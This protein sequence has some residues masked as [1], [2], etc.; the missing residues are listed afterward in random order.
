MMMPSKELIT[1]SDQDPLCRIDSFLSLKF[2]MHSRAYFQYL[3]ENQYIK[4]NGASIKKREK[5]LPGDQIEVTFHSKTPLN[6][7]PQE[8]PLSL[9]YEDDYFIAINK[10]KHLVVHPAPGNPD[11]TLVNGLLYHYKDLKSQDPIRPG[12]VHR[13]DKDTSGV[14][15]IA[16]T[17]S[18]HQALSSLFKERLIHKEYLALCLGH[19]GNK[20]LHHRLGRDPRQRKKMTLVP[21][22]GKEAITQ[23]ETLLF[24]EGYSW[25][26]ITPF[27]G[28]THQI[29]VHLHSIGCPIVGDPLYGSLRVN[30][31]LGVKTQ[32]LHAHILRFKHPFKEIM[33]TLEAP[34]PEELKELKKRLFLAI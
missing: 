24:K 2:P 3:I 7:A 5:L 16:K 1:V 17:S 23:I 20:T 15:L 8:M 14:L 31:R 33:I 10:P 11:H 27:T 21:E 32:A 29:R 18:A 19:P 4:L 26:K 34:I 25:V 6:A 13:L 12:I 30:Q 9:L 28:R 22:G